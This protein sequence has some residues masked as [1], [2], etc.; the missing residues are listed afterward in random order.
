MPHAT[1]ALA[2]FGLAII[3]L[4]MM[5]VSAMRRHDGKALELVTEYAG[6]CFIVETSLL[7][8]S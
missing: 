7:M 4:L 6:L 2:V 5:L 1:V 3:T 8:F